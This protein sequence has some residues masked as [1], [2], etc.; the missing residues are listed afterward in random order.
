MSIQYP[1]LGFELLNMSRLPLPLDRAPSIMSV[2]C[3]IVSEIAFEK[4]V[5]LFNNVLSVRF[6]NK[7][8]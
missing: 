1:V 2:Y 6:V 5:K 8:N 3:Y 4:A 7:Q